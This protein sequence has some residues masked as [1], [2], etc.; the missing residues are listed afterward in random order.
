MDPRAGSQIQMQAG[1][2]M[3]ISTESHLPIGAEYRWGAVTLFAVFQSRARPCLEWHALQSAFAKLKQELQCETLHLVLGVVRTQLPV[4]G[5]CAFCSAV[6][7][8]WTH[9]P[10]LDFMEAKAAVWCVV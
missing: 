5:E 2:K 3:H 9:V 7:K 4:W 8:C 6:E 10:T 1:N